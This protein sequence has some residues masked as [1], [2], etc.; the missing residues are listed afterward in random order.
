MIC[1]R[2][3]DVNF[4]HLVRVISATFLHKVT[5]HLFVINK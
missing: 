2:S 3:G 4:D 5:L 1:S